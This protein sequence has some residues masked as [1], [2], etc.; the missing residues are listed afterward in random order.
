ME[1]IIKGSP[2]EIADLA[3]EL[4]NRQNDEDQ[5]VRIPIKL[6]DITLKGCYLKATHDNFSTNS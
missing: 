3:L 6:G 2:K 5:K 4:Q 1:I